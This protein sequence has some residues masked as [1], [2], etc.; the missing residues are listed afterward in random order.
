MEKRLLSFVIPCYRSEKSISRVVDE[1]ITEVEKRSDIFDYEITLVND[2]SP[3][4][5][6]EVIRGLCG[7]NPKIKAISFSRNFGQHA[8]LMAGYRFSSGEIII[9]LDDDGQAPVE[10]VYRLVDK[11]DEGFDAVFGEYSSV[12]QNAFRRV[13]SH[14]NQFMAHA[15]I[16]QPHGVV[17][18]SFFAM[19][20]FVAKE[21]IKYDKSFPYIGGLIFRTTV[22]VTNVAVNQRERIEGR[23][24]YNLFKLVKLWLNG[25]T[26]FSVM[27]LRISTVIGAFCA[28]IGFVYGI[29]TIIR[30]ILNPDIMMGYSSTMAVVLFVGGVIMMMLG[31]IGEYIGRIYICIN[32]S[33]QYVIK[34]MIN[35][36]EKSDGKN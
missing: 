21:M 36:E 25:F 34:D 8:A 26:A 27:P 9:T 23:S 19:R 32:N 10:C 1:L 15:M 5:V 29:I 7:D 33:P 6:F 30:K 35:N 24:G 31:M 3:D 13:G 17:G 14:L 11:L 18:N 28:L 2:C 12:K 20:G 4:N 16:G 22:N